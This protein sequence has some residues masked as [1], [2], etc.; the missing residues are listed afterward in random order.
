M[1]KG[2]F[3]VEETRIIREML[4]SSDVFLNV[5]ANV[6]YYAAHALQAGVSTV[7]FEPHPD[8]VA[9]L[10]RNLRVNRWNAEVHCTACGET[11]DVLELYGGGTAASLL[12]GWAGQSISHVNLVPV[13]PL[14]S[15][16]GNRFHGQRILC[17]VDV[18]GAE[19]AVLSGA[20]QFLNRTPRPVWVVEICIDVHQPD[21]KLNA[22]LLETFDVFYSRN[23]A[24]FMLGG[25]FRE[26]RREEVERIAETGINSLEGHNFLF[27]T[28]L[29][30]VEMLKGQP[31]FCNTGIP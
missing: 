31:D 15:L 8:N 12:P 24:A 7:L 4:K 11:N 22:K 6:G 5:G 27:T 19:L 13:T 9:M 26:I 3:E 18:E 30:L 20:A 25:G 23:Y 10:L 16:V 21:G 29:N 17:L 28:D 2:S 1:Q 14:D